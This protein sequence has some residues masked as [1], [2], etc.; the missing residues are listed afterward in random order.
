MAFLVHYCSLSQW[1]EWSCRLFKLYV[2]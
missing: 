1:Y 2:T